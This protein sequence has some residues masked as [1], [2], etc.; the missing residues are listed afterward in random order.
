MPEFHTL[1]SI[2]SIPLYLQIICL[3]LGIV[4]GL[5]F[6]KKNNIASLAIFFVLAGLGIVSWHT[7][8]VSNSKNS[9]SDELYPFYH[10]E[11]KFN[12]VKRIKIEG[13]RLTISG[14]SGEF[15]FYTGYYPLGLDRTAV[16]DTVQKQG[17]CLNKSNNQCVEIQFVSP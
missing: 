9:F 14:P 4:A 2:F 8:V 13:H 3:L 12:A 11:I 15:S 7:V 5:V 10:R 1:D 16:W 6:Y 17:N